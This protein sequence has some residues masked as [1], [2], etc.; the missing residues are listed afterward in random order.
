MSKIEMLNQESLFLHEVN[1]I[2]DFST[3]LFSEN[4]AAQQGNALWHQ[5]GNI[6]NYQ[7]YYK[8]DQLTSRFFFFNF[9]S[10]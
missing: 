7:N 5:G 1:E 8:C 3:D 10:I 9:L 4:R 6:Q 2:P